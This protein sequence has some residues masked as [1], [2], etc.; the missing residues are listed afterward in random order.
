MC[1]GTVDIWKVTYDYK[2]IWEKR[3]VK[4]VQQHECK[5]LFA[6]LQQFAVI[7]LN[8]L[9]VLPYI[10]VVIFYSKASKGFLPAI[11]NW[12]VSSYRADLPRLQFMFT[13]MRYETFFI[14]CIQ[15]TTVIFI[16][17]I[18]SWGK[19]L[20]LL[21]S[22]WFTPLGNCCLHF[23]TVFSL[24]FVSG[25]KHSPGRIVMWLNSAISLLELL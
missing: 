1:R 17:F 5:S 11:R 21:F 13:C 25:S 24:L 15:K 23:I 12:F 2:P 9:G 14:V 22:S 16:S 7:L 10:V 8:H 3:L 6:F 19:D 18:S 4:W 20:R